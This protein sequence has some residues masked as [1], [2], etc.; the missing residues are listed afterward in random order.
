MGAPSRIPSPLGHRLL[1][2]HFLLYNGPHCQAATCSL[3]TLIITITNASQSE[4]LILSGPRGSCSKAS[5]LVLPRVSAHC[6]LTQHHR[7]H[8]PYSHQGSQEN[9]PTVPAA[10][11]CCLVWQTG[12][13]PCDA[14]S[15]LSSELSTTSCVSTRSPLRGSQPHSATCLVATGFLH[16]EAP[17]APLPTGYP[18]DY[19]SCIAVHAVHTVS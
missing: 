15:L 5:P 4:M 14:F 16:A 9:P 2:L 6:T 12:T 13:H 3:I 7:E 10:A 18:A 1:K 19:A 8:Y 17:Q 11:Q